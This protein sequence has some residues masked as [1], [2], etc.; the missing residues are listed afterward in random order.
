[1]PFYLKDAINSSTVSS[2]FLPKVSGSSHIVRI[3]MTSDV[4][5]KRIIGNGGQKSACVLMS[6]SQ[7]NLF[8]QEIMICFLI[9][10]NNN[11]IINNNNNSNNGDT[12]NN[13]NDKNIN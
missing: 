10:F 9:K 3:P 4:E 8:S 7:R 11:R 13:Y 2:N 12:S 1:M 6:T 5:P